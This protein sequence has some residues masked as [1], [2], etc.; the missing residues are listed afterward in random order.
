MYKRERV[1]VKDVPCHFT[2]Q[3]SPVQFQSLVLKR[4]PVT[5][6]LKHHGPLLLRTIPNHDY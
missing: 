2:V 5:L 3:F 6:R 4:E 1:L